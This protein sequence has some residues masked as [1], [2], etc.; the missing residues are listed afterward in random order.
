MRANF[1]G[2]RSTVRLTAI[3]IAVLVAANIAA[4]TDAP[5]AKTSVAHERNPRV[6]FIT[7]KDSPL[8]D[9]E[10]SRLR[11]PG[12]EFEKMRAAGWTIGTGTD[13]LVQIVDRNDVAD[14][15][16]KMDV[17]EFPA[18]ACIDHGEVVRYFRSGCTTPLDAWTFGFLAK[19]VNERPKG[20]VLEVARVES[21]GSYPLRGN[22]WSVEGDWNPT[23]DKVITHLRGPNHYWQLVAAWKIDDWSV[24]E[25]R[26][27]HDDLHERYDTG[28]SSGSQSSGGNSSD[29]SRPKSL[30]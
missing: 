12:G 2:L 30:R 13:K 17:H 26:S 22:H 27:L 8:S 3:A 29:Y 18:V 23:R 28:G 5:A 7:S 20:A 15:V 6:L 9:K 14:L 24:E 10:L 21:T 19:G 1:V 25:L 11:Q 16:E 4:A